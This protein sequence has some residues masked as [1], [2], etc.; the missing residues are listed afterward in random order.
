MVILQTAAQGSG[1]MGMWM[2]FILIPFIG[3]FFFLWW[4]IIDIVAKKR[5]RSTWLWFF[6][7]IFI[8]I[9]LALLLL[10]VLGE[11]DEKR[12]ERIAEEERIRK[13]IRGE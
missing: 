4:K 6:I 9:I 2:L 12:K 7:S 11:T 5:G 3:G 13:D 1:S 8:S 10:L